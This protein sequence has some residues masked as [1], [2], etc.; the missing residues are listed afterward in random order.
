MINGNLVPTSHM[1][2]GR[3]SQRARINTSD[4]CSGV[5]NVCADCLDAKYNYGYFYEL[6]TKYDVE[7]I[8]VQKFLTLNS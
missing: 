6:A 3:M 8:K 4:L 1:N 5:L 2:Y 7:R